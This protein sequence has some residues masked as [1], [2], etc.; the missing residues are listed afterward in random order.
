MIEIKRREVNTFR[1]FEQKTFKILV[2]FFIVNKYN[3]CHYIL[4]KNEEDVE[5]LK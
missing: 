2:N 3:F 5:F 1:G 4:F